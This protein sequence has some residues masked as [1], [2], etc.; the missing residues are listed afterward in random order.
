MAKVPSLNPNSTVYIMLTKAE[1]LSI[2]AASIQGAIFLIGLCIQVKTYFVLKKEKPLAWKIYM[3]HGIVMLI[4]YPFL[5]SF[6]T[7]TEFVNPLSD[8]TGNW[9]CHIAFFIR[10]F[11]VTAVYTHSFIIAIIKHT[12]IVHHKS[13]RQFGQGKAEETFFQGY[14]VF[15][16]INAFALSL[17]PGWTEMFSENHGCYGYDDGTTNITAPAYHAF[18]RVVLCM[19]DDAPGED[20]GHYI[21]YVVTQCYCFLQTVGG[22]ICWC[23]LAE[24]FLYYSIF[25]YISR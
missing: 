5:V 25:A 24:A 18:S 15:L 2:I 7:V 21:I 12:F 23:N 4:H 14:I 1:T 20:T 10:M 3:L 22:V 16:T 8:L 9:V 13:V 11:G 17:R 6:Q 19:S